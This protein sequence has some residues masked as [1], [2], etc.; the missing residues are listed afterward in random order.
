M[1][2]TIFIETLLDDCGQHKYGIFRYSEEDV[3]TVVYGNESYK[4]NMLVT[5]LKAIDTNAITSLNG[6]ITTDTF[7]TYLIKSVSPYKWKRDLYGEQFF[8]LTDWRTKKTK[9]FTNIM[10]MAKEVIK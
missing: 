1:K 7:K 10:D 3:Y 6:I 9:R 4:T 2:A 8:I 5:A